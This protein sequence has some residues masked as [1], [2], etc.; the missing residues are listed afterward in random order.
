MQNEYDESSSYKHAHEATT[1]NFVILKPLSNSK[2]DN[3]HLQTLKPLP[4]PNI[5]MHVRYW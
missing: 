5:I 2:Q 1:L 4:R 3:E